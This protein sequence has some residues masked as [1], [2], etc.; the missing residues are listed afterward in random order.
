MSL[1]ARIAERPALGLE[2]SGRRS[3]VVERNHH[4]E[5]HSTKIE[6]KT[7]RR[8]R[9]FLLLLKKDFFVGVSRKFSPRTRTRGELSKIES[10]GAFAEKL[11]G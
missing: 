6:K 1:A 5:L 3:V 4:V 11:C 7:G 8:K 9:H 10:V 2:L